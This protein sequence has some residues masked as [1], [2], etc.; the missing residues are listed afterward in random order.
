MV[1]VVSKLQEVSVV[2][3]TS[4]QTILIRTTA[5]VTNQNLL[6]NKNQQDQVVVEDAVYDEMML[7]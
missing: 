7:Q 4:H 2:N 5:M 1:N 3:E 6:D